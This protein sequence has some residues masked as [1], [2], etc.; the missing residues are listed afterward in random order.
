MM[1]I[2]KCDKG[3]VRHNVNTNGAVKHGLSLGHS[4]ETVPEFVDNSST[5]FVKC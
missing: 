1:Q 3:S 5:I 4:D 2:C